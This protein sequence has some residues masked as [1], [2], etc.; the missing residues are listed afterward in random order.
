MKFKGVLKVFVLA[1]LLVPSIASAKLSK[2]DEAAIRA[3]TQTW[4]EGAKAADWARVAS[5]YAVDGVLLPPHVPMVT[6]REAIQ[7]HFASMPHVSDLAF[8]VKEI[9]GN[10]DIAYVW[11]TFSLTMTPEGAGPVKDSGQFI[12]IRRKIDGEWLISRDVYNSDVPMVME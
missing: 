7:A 9:D 4:V 5:L 8:E 10:G 11:G 12:E 3:T 2:D 1:V 6:G